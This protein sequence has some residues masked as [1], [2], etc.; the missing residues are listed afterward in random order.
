M[1]AG[2]VAA[3]STHQP[4]LFEHD[5]DYFNILSR[6]GQ[7]PATVCRT[8]AQGLNCGEWQPEALSGSL[9]GR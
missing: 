1:L 5:S 4:R 2:V 8:R 9:A 7:V 3:Y 6:R